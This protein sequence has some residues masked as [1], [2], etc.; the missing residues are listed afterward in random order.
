MLQLFQCCVQLLKQILIF[1]DSQEKDAETLMEETTQTGT[2]TFS[3]FCPE[4]CH[5]VLYSAIH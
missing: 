5:A 4:F 3:Y 1:T 2:V